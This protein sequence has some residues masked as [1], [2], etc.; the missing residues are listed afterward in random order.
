MGG[1]LAM[2]SLLSRPSNA[3]GQLPTLEEVKKKHLPQMPASEKIDGYEFCHAC[4]GEGFVTVNECVSKLSKMSRQMR[5]M[6][7]KCGGEGM[8]DRKKEKREKEE[9]ARREAEATKAKVEVNAVETPA[10][11]VDVE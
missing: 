9:K 10:C 11:T 6:C 8:I 2:D 3:A 1:A 4:H 7:D 5:E